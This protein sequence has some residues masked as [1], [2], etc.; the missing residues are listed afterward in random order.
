MC[1]IATCHRACA[2]LT[3]EDVMMRDKLQLSGKGTGVFA[4]G[5][6]MAVGSFLRNVHYV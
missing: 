5:L 2:T 4:D 6:K 3:K 1:T